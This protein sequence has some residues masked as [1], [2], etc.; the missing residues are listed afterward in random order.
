MKN[1][2]K[3]CD[4]IGIIALAGNCNEESIFRAQKNI[5]SLGY[6]VK[7]SNN[8]FDENKY[9]AGNDNEKIKELHKFFLDDDIKLIL[10]ARGGYGSLRLIDKIDY[11][12]I[13]KHMKPFCGFSDITA[14]LLMIYK[15]TGMITYHAPM[16][17]SD[18]GLEQDLSN[19]TIDNFF[20]TINSDTLEI[21]CTNILNNT[22]TKG[23][24]WGGNLA[25]M[26]SLCGINFIPNEDFIFF[27]EDLNEPVYKIDRMFHQLFNIKKFKKNCKAILVGE[28]LNIDNK[29]WLNEL[30]IEIGTK[31]KIPI[32]HNNSITHGNNKVTLP[33]GASCILKSSKLIIKK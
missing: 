28:F 29:A 2:L 31:F 1:L 32:A 17:S 14:L 22:N 9:L 12:L 13:S 30:L 20:N 6:N 19:F 8:I 33:I 25:T 21:E 10:N 24:L 3:K 4:T 27:T 16:A 23:V 26:C 7:L 5:E 18:F 15:K 11:K